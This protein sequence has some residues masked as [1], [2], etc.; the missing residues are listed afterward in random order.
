MGRVPHFRL[1]KEK[2]MRFLPQKLPRRNSPSAFLTLSF[3]RELFATESESGR[4]GSSWLPGCWSLLTVTG[5]PPT[6]RHPA[7][8]GIRRGGW[9]ALGGVAAAPKD[10]QDKSPASRGSLLITAHPPGT[11]FSP[12]KGLTEKLKDQSKILGFYICVYCPYPRAERMTMNQFKHTNHGNSL[13]V[14]WTQHFHC[15]GQGSIPGWGTKIPTSCVA[16]PQT[17]K[18]KKHQPC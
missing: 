14:Q 2:G 17:N 8:G 18:Q 15:Q 1:C 3:S 5:P 9:A 6:P 4:F 10:A 13:A 11:A 12:E 16:R 7:T